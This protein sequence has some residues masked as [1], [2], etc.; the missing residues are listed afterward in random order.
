MGAVTLFAGVVFVIFPVSVSA[1]SEGSA[2][3]DRLESVG[4]TFQFVSAECKQCGNCTMCDILSVPIGIY[5]IMISF[6]GI[7][8]L[9]MLL[10]GGMVW[11][12]PRGDDQKIQQGKEIMS[13]TFFGMMLVLSSWIIVNT[14]IIAVTP[15]YTADTNNPQQD[16]ERKSTLLKSTARLFSNS[17]PWNNLCDG[18]TP[19]SCIDTKVSTYIARE[20]AKAEAI[21]GG[22]RTGSLGPAPSC[23]NVG[24]GTTQA[25]QTNVMTKVSLSD[26]IQ[27]D[28][29][30]AAKLACGA[31]T[32]GGPE[33]GNKACAWSVN[34]ILNKAN[35]D[36]IVRSRGSKDYVLDVQAGLNAGR[37]DLIL[38][39]NA[40]CGDIMIAEKADSRHIGICMG[41]ACKPVLSNASSKARFAWFSNNYMCAPAPSDQYC[42]GTVSIY[43]VKNRH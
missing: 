11:M 33:G 1:T 2:T 28:I 15:E 14:I 18:E 26:N 13:R 42:G 43:R 20:Q 5:R 6:V 19:P 17:L 25:M 12:M 38:T 32:S 41:P 16:Q 9:I 23:A 29:C 4:V 31:D 21:G 39:A 8:A 22:G 3:I 35:V 37:G 36:T 27:A 34:Y 7:G 24:G 30:N 10:Y 40:M